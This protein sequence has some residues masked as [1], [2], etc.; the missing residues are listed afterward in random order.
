MKRVCLWGGII[1]RA[2]GTV[3]GPKQYNH[4][5]RLISLIPDSVHS[6]L[7]S[8]KQRKE[9]NRVRDSVRR[10]RSRTDRICVMLNRDSGFI[11]A[12]PDRKHKHA[13]TRVRKQCNT[14]PL[15]AGACSP[16]QSQ[17]CFDLNYNT[18]AASV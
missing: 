2:P 9:R 18:H 12:L 14:R 1:M 5:A 15:A 7:C 6:D 17:P 11:C 8:Q 4:F 16:S 13:V 10:E 3:D